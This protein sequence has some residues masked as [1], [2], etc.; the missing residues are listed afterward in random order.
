MDEQWG[1]VVLLSFALLPLNYMRGCELS[2]HWPGGEWMADVPD[3]VSSGESWTRL[4]RESITARAVW[5]YVFIFIFRIYC[6][7]RK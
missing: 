7:A 5:K 2:L 1:H 4:H 6:Q 3:E